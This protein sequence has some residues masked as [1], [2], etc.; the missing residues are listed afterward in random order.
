MAMLYRYIRARIETECGG[1]ARL[2]SRRQPWT[3]A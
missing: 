2:V 3:D 1:P